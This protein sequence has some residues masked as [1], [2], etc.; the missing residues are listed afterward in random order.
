[1]AWFIA[2]L[3][4]VVAFTIVSGDAAL[5]SFAFNYINQIFSSAASILL[6]V[7]VYS[8]YLDARAFEA[9]K[10]A[11]PSASFQSGQEP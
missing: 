6:A 9:D 2:L 1:V 11:G 10:Y 7:C 3:L 8:G 5:N 4:C